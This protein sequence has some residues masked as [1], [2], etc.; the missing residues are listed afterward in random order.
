MNDPE[1]WNS[2]HVPA[3]DEHTPFSARLDLAYCQTVESGEPD[4]YKALRSKRPNDPLG[5]LAAEALHLTAQLCRDVRPSTHRGGS[6]KDCIQTGAGSQRLD[7]PYLANALCQKP[8]FTNV[9]KLIGPT[10][11]VALFRLAAPRLVP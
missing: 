3:F 10:I 7:V 11:H 1:S 9:F 5:S 6:E 4:D 8:R 2:P